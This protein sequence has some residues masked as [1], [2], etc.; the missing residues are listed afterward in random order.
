[1]Q[2]EQHQVEIGAGAVGAHETPR[3][4]EER[5]KDAHHQQ[6]TQHAHSG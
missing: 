1:M 6:T 4:R 3:H 5:G 2:L